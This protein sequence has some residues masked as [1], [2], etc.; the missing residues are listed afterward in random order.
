[1]ATDAL[2]KFPSTAVTLDQAF[3]DPET[4][5]ER[6][7]GTWDKHKKECQAKHKSLATDCDHLRS[8]G[9]EVLMVHQLRNHHLMYRFEY[10][11]KLAKEV[12]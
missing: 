9:M 7:E 12:H 1:M 10:L 8:N 11:R 3:I 4:N 2:G 6:R 5:R